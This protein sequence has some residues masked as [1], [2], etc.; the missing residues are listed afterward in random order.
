VS[1]PSPSDVGRTG[2]RAGAR[3]GHRP[4]ALSVAL[5][6]TA[7]L[8]VAAVVATWVSRQST[9]PGTLETRPVQV[10]GRPLPPRGTGPDPAVG[11]TMPELLGASFNGARVSIAKD[12]HPKVVMFLAHWCPHCQREVPE[13][14]AWL[15]HDGQQRTVEF[16]SVATATTR[17]R[18]NYPPSEWL[19]GEAWPLP[20]LA[21]DA[22]N[23][24]ARA[25]GL[26]AFPFFVFVNAR[27]EVVARHAGE[28][29]V[30]EFEKMVN[31]LR[32]KPRSPA[33]S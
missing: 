25:V 9:G 15:R 18:P 21:D 19:R 1:E 22:D 20:V 26:S 4:R 23:D 14:A 16:Y 31:S 30:A 6:V 3:A 27:N 28:L 13:L 24:A 12:G 33:G 8:A 17:D 10:R 5:G 32:E 11:V 2:P 7:L 29:T